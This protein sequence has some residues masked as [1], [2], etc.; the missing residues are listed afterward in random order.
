M[1][2]LAPP[3]GLSLEEV[4]EYEQEM[5]EKTN[6]KVKASQNGTGEGGAPDLQSRAEQCVCAPVCVCVG[7]TRVISWKVLNVE[8]GR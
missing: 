2:S 3:A 7:G 8:E 6:D 4:R 1:C 5:Q